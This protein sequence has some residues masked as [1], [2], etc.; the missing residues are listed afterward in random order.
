MKTSAYF[1]LSI[2]V[3]L[4]AAF[5]PLKAGS[6]NASNPV[7]I[8]KTVR[9]SFAGDMPPSKAREDA[10][11]RAQRSALEEAGVYLDSLSVVQEGMLIKDEI[12]M[13]A[14]AVVKVR[15]LE[16]RKFATEETFGLEVTIEAEIDMLVLEERIDKMLAEREHLNR[17]Q[18]L[19][20]QNKDLMMKIALLEMQL[21]D[22]AAKGIAIAPAEPT[23]GGQSAATSSDGKMDRSQADAGEAAASGSGADRRKV[24]GD[25]EGYVEDTG[26]RPLGKTATTTTRP[27]GKRHSIMNF[28]FGANPEIHEARSLAKNGY[29]HFV[30]KDYDKALTLYTQAIEQL[31]SDI[32]TYQA[33]SKKEFEAVRSVIEGYMAAALATGK[34]VEVVQVYQFY[35]KFFRNG[36]TI[37]VHMMGAIATLAEG[38]YEAHLQAWKLSSHRSMYRAQLE[39]MHIAFT[40][41]KVK[42]AIRKYK[43]QSGYITKQQKAMLAELAEASGAVDVFRTHLSAYYRAKLDQR[44]VTGPSYMPFSPYMLRESKGDGNDSDHGDKG[45]NSSGGM[46][47]TG[48]NAT[49]VSGRTGG[50]A[51]E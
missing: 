44:H 25:A 35:K 34:T 7:V 47:E 15:V 29:D 45:Q 37:N 32:E 13:L 30:D 3:I 39:S 51:T 49:S 16:E 42:N 36:E 46:G 18:E 9:Q 23:E 21:D 11:R 5:P 19:D 28:L 4:L 12:R 26:K 8:T 2:I 31:P 6:E 38:D 41:G 40:T 24:S 27:G 17:L 10:L 33:I 48:G 50:S 22:A 1:S 20:A 43:E 14:A